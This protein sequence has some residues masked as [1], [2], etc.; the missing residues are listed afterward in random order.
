M[1]ESRRTKQ[2]ITKQW[3]TVGMTTAALFGA[4]AFSHLALANTDTTTEALSEAVNESAMTTQY[5]GDALYIPENTIGNASQGQ[6]VGFIDSNGQLHDASGKVSQDYELGLWV[7]G[8]ARVTRHP[9]FSIDKNYQIVDKET[10]QVKGNLTDYVRY[11]ISNTGGAM[12]N[13]ITIST[14]LDKLIYYGSVYKAWS[15]PGDVAPSNL[16]ISDSAKREEDSFLASTSPGEYGLLLKSANFKTKES[17][18]RFRKEVADLARKAG[19]FNGEQI[20]YD[21]A[22]IRQAMTNLGYDE[23][24][25]KIE[26]SPASYRFTLSFYGGTQGGAVFFNRYKSIE[27]WANKEGKDLL[28]RANAAAAASWGVVVPRS[29]LKDVYRLYHPGLQVHLYSADSNERNVLRANGWQYEGVAWKTESQQGD[30][31]YRLYHPGMRYHLYTKDAN[32][33]QVLASRGWK[34]EGIAYRSSGP[35]RVYRLYH[36]AIRKHLY[37]RDANERSILSNRGWKDEGVSWNSQ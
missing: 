14:T 5:L 13:L 4:L 36:P 19:L 31:V 2:T 6:I 18:D 32:E 28:A 34:Q 17:L 1:E 27:E 20:F 22:G 33:Y 7:A 15:A 30:P 37:T 21:S 3:F 23:K 25:Y 10:G 24:L 16:P 9:K 8:S 12:D 11:R 29:E 35:V 26:E